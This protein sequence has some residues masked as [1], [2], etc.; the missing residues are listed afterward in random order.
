MASF[1]C[2]LLLCL[3][4]PSPQL[5]GIE[6]EDSSALCSKGVNKPLFSVRVS[7][8]LNMSNNQMISF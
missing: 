2:R 5:P 6:H 4:L 7:K 8:Y 1:V 3:H